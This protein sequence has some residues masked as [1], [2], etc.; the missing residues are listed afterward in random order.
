[1]IAVEP[2]RTKRRGA[3]IVGQSALFIAEGAES[4]D[5]AVGKSCRWTHPDPWV[6]GH[7]ITYLHGPDR[8]AVVSRLV[9]ARC[10]MKL[11]RDEL[12]SEFTVLW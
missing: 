2:K 8:E 5:A 1:M 12:E 7:L 6:L 11:T 10:A 9:E 4:F 3:A